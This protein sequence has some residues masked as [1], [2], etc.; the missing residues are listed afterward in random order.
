MALQTVSAALPVMTV[1]GPYPMDLRQ[2]DMRQLAAA[3]FGDR[4][5]PETFRVTFTMRMPRYA[6]MPVK[7]ALEPGA[8]RSISAS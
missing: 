7:G 5:R 1:R 4:E 6:R 2:P 8:N 3:Q